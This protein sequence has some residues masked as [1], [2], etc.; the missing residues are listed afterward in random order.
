MGNYESLRTSASIELEVE[1]KDVPDVY[2]TMDAEL[3]RMLAA[4]L[5][6]ASGLTDVR[7]SY[8]LT[9]TEGR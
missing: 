9:W 8:I 2:Q 4:D 6:E 1:P 3:D 5:K 7:N